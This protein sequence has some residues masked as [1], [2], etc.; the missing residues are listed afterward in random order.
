MIK[1]EF[2]VDLIKGNQKEWESHDDVIH[3]IVD[4]HEGNDL[5]I[6]YSNG[7][8]HIEVRYATINNLICASIDIRKFFQDLGIEQTMLD[9]HQE[10]EKEELLQTLGK[11]REAVAL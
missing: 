6:E 2:T 3:E 7:S 1:F 4:R 5:S 9:V 10:E 11:L 8:R